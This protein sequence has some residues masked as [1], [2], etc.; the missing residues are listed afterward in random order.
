M[1]LCRV[2][3]IQTRR[4]SKSLKT[5][6]LYG[7]ARRGIRNR[8]TSMRF[9]CHCGVSGTLEKGSF[10]HLHSSHECSVH[11]RLPG[12]KILMAPSILEVVWFHLHLRWESHLSPTLLLSTP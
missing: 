1:C 4:L 12:Y 3:L 10:V 8:H 2:E 6:I 5:G 11:Q 7:I 9:S